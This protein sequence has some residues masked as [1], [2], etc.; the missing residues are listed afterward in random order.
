MASFLVEIKHAKPSISQPSIPHSALDPGATAELHLAQADLRINIG[1][2]LHLA[3][4]AVPDHHAVHHV[5]HIH[6]KTTL[7]PK[8]RNV[9]GIIT[10]Q[11]GRRENG[12]G[13]CPSPFPLARF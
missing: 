3:R 13:I 7:L 6:S 10:L 9:R 4:P 12:A 8:I 2:R 5:N 11:H 1:K